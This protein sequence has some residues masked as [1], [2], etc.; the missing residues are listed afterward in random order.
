MNNNTN[1]TTNNSQA[2]NRFGYILHLWS[3]TG[4]WRASLENLETG[5]RFGFENLEQLFAYLMDLIEGKFNKPQRGEKDRIDESD[6]GST[7]CE[8]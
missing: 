8:C 1:H 3:C 4:Q 2:P 6:S 7:S 5:K